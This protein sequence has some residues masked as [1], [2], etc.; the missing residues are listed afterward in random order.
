MFDRLMLLLAWV[1]ALLFVAAGCML[2]YEV[3]AR[4]F[5]IR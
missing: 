3:I 2:T 1:A 4:Y 5:F